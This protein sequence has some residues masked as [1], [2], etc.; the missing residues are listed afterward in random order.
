MLNFDVL[1]KFH[2]N[3]PFID[4]LLQMPFYAN[5]LKEILSKKRKIDQHGT[6]ALSEECTDVV[7]IKLCKR[8]V[9]TWF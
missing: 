2:V 7:R 1:K 5:F 8:S 9:V 6:I 4:A 3:S